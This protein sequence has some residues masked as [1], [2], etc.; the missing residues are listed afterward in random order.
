MDE[1]VVRLARA[2]ACIA[3]LR[4]LGLLAPA[5]ELSPTE[6]ARQLRMPPPL[7][8]AHLSRLTAVG[9]I[10]RR[11]S[12]A[13]C[14]CRAESP[15]SDQALSGQLAEWLRQLMAK[16]SRAAK[17]YGVAQL[18]NSPPD[19]EKTQLHR[20]V[21]QAATAFASVRRLQIL[22]RLAEAGPVDAATLSRELHMSCAAV[23]RNTAKLIR[24]GYV[25]AGRGGRLLTYRLAPEFKTPVHARLFEIVRSTWQR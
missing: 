23:S 7:V 3:R 17:N 12:G 15:Y 6:L 22:R 11:R 5:E 8:C 19:K 14:Y 20:V 2:I 4:I 10:L 24:R 25:R 9:L 13:W 1:L 21:F 16:P 18:R